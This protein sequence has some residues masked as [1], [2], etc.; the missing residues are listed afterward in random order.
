MPSR[1]YRNNNPGNIR[2][3]GPTGKVYP[4]V[5]RWNGKDDGKNYAKFL[6]VADG[7]AALADLMATV[8][9]NMTISMVI[10]KYAPSE[11]KNDPEKYVRVICG[12]AGIDNR[13][14]I[15]DLPPFKFFDLCK[16]ITKFEG[17]FY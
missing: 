5:E 4:V 17:W 2:H 9:E 12:W 15:C 10:A 14:Y 3:H 1:S 11:D 7:C 6:S 16:A 8:Y 13:N